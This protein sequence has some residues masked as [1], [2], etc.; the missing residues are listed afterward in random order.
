[1][2]AEQPK[3]STLNDQVSNANAAVQRDAELTRKA[4]IPKPAADR[5]RLAAVA[6]LALVATLWL[7][8]DRL[9]GGAPDPARVRDG[10]Q[11]GLQAVAQSVQAR[12]DETGVLPASLDE[13]G[14]GDAP[15]SYSA[16]NNAFRLTGITDAGDTLSYESPARPAPEAR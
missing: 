8:K 9:S 13:L 3:G 12:W 15:I 11:Q 14:W 5:R 2:T 6:V 4:E 7:N 10:M 1:M 16:T